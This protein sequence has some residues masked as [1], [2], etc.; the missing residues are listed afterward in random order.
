VLTDRLGDLVADGEGRVEA[1]Q[2]VLEDEP[3]LL[4]AQTAHRLLGEFEH[5]DPVEHDFA[6]HDLPRRIGDESRDRQG[7]HALTAAR[8]ADETEGLAVVEIEGHVVDGLDDAV[9]REE[10]GG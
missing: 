1:G 8:L 6:A 10:V 4:A 2:W 3:D 7:R 9:R 5:V